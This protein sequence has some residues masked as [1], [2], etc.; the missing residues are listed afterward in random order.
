[1]LY[2]FG[3]GGRGWEIIMPDPNYFCT[4]PFSEVRINHNGSIN[5]CHYAENS[6]IKN[7]E[8]ILEMSINE[9][10]NNS[11]SIQER[12]ILLEGGKL[13]RCERCYHGEKIDEAYFRKRRNL[14]FGI[15]PDRHFQQ[16]FSESNIQE[17]INN[18]NLQPHFYH[19]SLS[20]LCNL[21]CIMCNSDNS[22]IVARDFKTAGIISE[23]KPTLLDWTTNKIVW[24]SFLDHIVKNKKIISVHFMGGEPLY[25]KKFYE[26]IN[27]CIDMK[28]Y[29]FHLTFVTNGTIVPDKEF[30]EKLK[31]FKSVQIEVSIEGFDDS[32][33][34]VRFPSDWKIIKKNIEKYMLYTNENISLCLRTVPQFFTLLDYDQLLQWCLDN[35]IIVDSNV[36]TNPIFFKPAYLPNEIKTIIKAKLEKF[37]INDSNSKISSI[38]V[39]DSSNIETCISNNVKIILNLL[40]E[41]VQDKE[42]Q[43]QDMISYLAKLDKVRNIDIRE[44]LPKFLNFIKENGYEEIRY[45]N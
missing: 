18:D 26:F 37:L 11:E 2:V 6:F 5:F 44:K 7:K 45:K 10:F 27:H 36:I 42:K 15:F 28:H 35:K 14:Q 12:K 3:S 9:Y 13:Q 17:Y 31:K 19:I 20:N 29:N 24:N 38:N 1:M 21:G 41:P 32:N 8:N 33:N 16:S 30:I 43:M 4:S 39:R 40:G 23:D 25:H 22:S 34:Y